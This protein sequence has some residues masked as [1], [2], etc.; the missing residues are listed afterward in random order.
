VVEA[1]VAREADAR[2]RLLSIDPLD[3][4]A[5][6]EMLGQDH[7]GVIKLLPQKKYPQE[8]LGMHGAAAY[9]DFARPSQHYRTGREMSLQDGRFTCSYGY[10]ADLGELSPA[11]V[12]TL[13][14]TPPPWADETLKGRWSDFWGR[15]E[16][17]PP[18]LAAS[19]GKSEHRG[20]PRGV[21]VKAQHAYMFRSIDDIIGSDILVGLCVLR[22][23]DDG[24]AVV[25][26]RILKE[27][28]RPPRR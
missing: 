4:A 28:G 8:L 19:L 13:T 6:A 26:F 14:E 3:T 18:G 17:L 27:F 15:R 5:A 7:S 24:S 22:V 23:C 1:R 16:D 25:A 20:G 11:R 9:Y 21:H 10:F 12:A 2:E